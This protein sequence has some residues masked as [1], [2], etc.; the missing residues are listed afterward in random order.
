MKNVSSY[1][2]NLRDGLKV[3]LV[4]VALGHFL[5]DSHRALANFVETLVSRLLLLIKSY[6]KY[7]I[8]YFMIN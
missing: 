8:K 7:I 6:K 3:L 4:L 5:D 2:H 1:L